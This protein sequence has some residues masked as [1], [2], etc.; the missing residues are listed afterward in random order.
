MLKKRGVVLWII[1]LAMIMTVSG[2]QAATVLTE[3]GRSPFHQPPLTSAEDLLAM[4]HNN[5]QE[6]KKGFELAERAELYQPFMEKVFTT[7]IEVVEFPNGSWFEWMF[8][9][10]KG[11]GSVKIAKDVTWANET[12]FQGF[13]FDIEHQGSIHTFVIPLACGNVALMGSR[14]VPQPFV[15]PAPVLP[16]PNQSPQCAAT[17]A[18]IRAFCGEMVAVDATAS[19]DPD[20][21]L[22]K[23]K[24]TFINSQGEVLSEQLIEGGVL[25]SSVALPCGTN[26]LQVT[27]VDNDGAEATSAACTQVVEGVKRIRPIA[28]AGIF[29]QWDPATYLFGRAGL[30]YRLSEDFSVLGMVGWAPRI[31]GSDGRSAGILDLLGEYSFGQRYFTH[32][33]VGAWLTNGDSDHDAED[34]QLDLIAGLGARVFGEPEAFNGSLFLEVRSAP[35]ELGDFAD[36]GR[37][38]LGL[39]LRF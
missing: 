37:V 39:R 10:K 23:K 15:A 38:G 21:T 3:M 22:V 19:S 24:I 27:V 30:E 18:P 7:T 4:L 34:S 35:D 1:A 20:G 13:Q 14:P 36:F 17:V 6:V 2:V 25:L 16:P 5:D 11:K 33:G 28:D 12:P 32:F 8:Y 9:K 29:Y 26:T 31:H